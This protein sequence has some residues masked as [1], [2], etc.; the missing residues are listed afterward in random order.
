MSSIVRPT[1]IQLTRRLV[2][3]SAA[4]FS[5]AIGYSQTA[6][7]WGQSPAEFA[8]D[9]D[10]TLRVAPYAFAIWGLIYLGVLAYAVRQ[11]LPQTGESD[12][13]RWFGWPSVAALL[14]I[15]W[16]IV[17]AALDWEPATIVLIFG[18]GAVLIAP[19]LLNARA[20]RALPRGDR[21]RWLTVWPLAMLAGWLTVAAPVNLLTVA[22]GNGALPAVLP[23]T[24]WALLAVAAVVALGLFVTWRTRLLAYPLPIAWGLLAVFVAEQ[25][26]NPGLA[27]PALAASAVVLVGG[28]ILVFQLRPGIERV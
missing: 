12:P 22:T 7:G 24:G 9:S 16:W 5:I 8:A 14:G 23:P 26:R 25:A 10:A 13:I 6:L 11:A 20:I 18:S 1:S 28:L 19:L 3:L 21:D 27:F 4:V 2:V 15:G 17:A